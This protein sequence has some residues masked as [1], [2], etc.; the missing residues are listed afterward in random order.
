MAWT[1]QPKRDAKSLGIRRSVIIGGRRWMILVDRAFSDSDG[2]AGTGIDWIWS[3][4]S[5]CE[6]VEVSALSEEASFER[7]HCAALDFS[8]MNRR[9]KM[10]KPI[11]ENPIA[12]TA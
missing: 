9:R 1:K 6:V 3:C 4:D 8:T 2:R 12:K 10:S 11:S 5:G 7:D